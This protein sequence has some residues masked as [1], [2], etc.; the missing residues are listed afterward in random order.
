LQ[1]QA[2]NNCLASQFN[3]D[4]FSKIVIKRISNMLAARAS[5]AALLPYQCNMQD[6]SPR[7]ALELLALPLQDAQQRQRGFCLL[8]KLAFE[9]PPEVSPVGQDRDSFLRKA[10]TAMMPQELV[11][12]SCS[13]VLH[14][15]VDI[16]ASA[17]LC[18]LRVL[19][20]LDSLTAKLMQ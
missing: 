14:L 9:L 10:R 13:E 6:Y 20:V 5:H 16:C 1:Q 11:S 12:T 3:L 4:K 17:P 18:A 15:P 19:R 2:A 7:Y 8:R